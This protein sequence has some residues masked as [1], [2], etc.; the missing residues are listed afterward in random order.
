M[1]M[2]PVCLARSDIDAIDLVL[3]VAADVLGAERRARRAAAADAPAP[4]GRVR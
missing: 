2:M 3:V 1:R 4:L